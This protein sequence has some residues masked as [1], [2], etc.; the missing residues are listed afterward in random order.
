MEEGEKTLL[1]V[2]SDLES[3]Q[4]TTGHPRDKGFTSPSAAGFPKF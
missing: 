1:S 3:S 4:A 2:M